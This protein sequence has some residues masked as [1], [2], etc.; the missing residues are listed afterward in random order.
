MFVLGLSLSY[1]S[2]PKKT[3]NLI[4]ES[5]L[6]Q[7]SKIEDFNTNREKKKDVVSS[8]KKDP[9]T[10]NKSTPTALNVLRY[11]YS[12]CNYSEHNESYITISTING[13]FYNI[14]F[15]VTIKTTKRQKTL[16]EC[17]KSENGWR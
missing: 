7:R 10:D 1:N 12:N 14:S 16:V 6:N 13:I 15:L 3:L 17:V 9:N 4:N 2:A 11:K 5:P 8:R